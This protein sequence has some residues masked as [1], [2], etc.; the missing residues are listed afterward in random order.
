MIKSL[1][2]S[3][4]HNQNLLI[5]LNE[6]QNLERNYLSFILNKLYYPKKEIIEPIVIQKQP[7]PA[8]RKLI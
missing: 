6:A 1:N 5:K 4:E 7:L 2:E 3:L 8:P